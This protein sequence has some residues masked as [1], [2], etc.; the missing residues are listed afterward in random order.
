M[1]FIDPGTGGSGIMLGPCHGV[2]YEWRT[3]S[4]SKQSIGF[5]LGD[6]FIK[7]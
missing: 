7:I 2:V 1:N 3:P 4:K 6:I 5:L